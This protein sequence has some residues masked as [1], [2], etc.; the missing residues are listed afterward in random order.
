MTTKKIVSIVFI[1]FFSVC[2]LVVGI[3][4]LG[5]QSTSLSKENAQDIIAQNFIAKKVNYIINNGQ[6]IKNYEIVV[7]ASTTVFSVLESLGQK[8][9]FTVT[10]KVYPEMGVLIQ[11]INGIISGTE[12]KYWQ[13]WVDDTLGEVACDNKFIKAGDKIEW[14]FDTVPTF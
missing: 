2:I 10:Y 9:K 3:Y 12:E 1:V 7:E 6:E 8:E 13:Y 5:Y 4:F 14:K 11:G